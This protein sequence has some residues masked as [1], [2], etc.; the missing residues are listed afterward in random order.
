VLP[1]EWIFPLQIGAVL[2]GF[3]VALYVLLRRAIRPGTTPAEGFREILPWAL[4]L[5][6]ITIVSLSI[7]N[8]PMEMRG[9]FNLGV[10]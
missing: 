9:T 7:F 10:R 1:Q 2:A 6:V 4:V 3:F 8:L 5:L